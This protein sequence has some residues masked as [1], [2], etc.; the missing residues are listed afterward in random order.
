MKNNSTKLI[1]SIAGNNIIQV[2]EM[3]KQAKQQGA[4]LAEIRLDFLTEK[5]LYAKLPELFEKSPIDLI[6]T[7]RT[8]NEGGNFLDNPA[9]RIK[10]LE[11]SARFERVKYIDCELDIIDK[12]NINKPMIAS[13]HLL[14]K[15]TPE[16]ILKKLDELNR[17]KSIVS[18][19][20][21][22]SESASQ[23][24]LALEIL[25]KNNEPAII[26]AMN[27][28]GSVSRIAAKKVE[29]F[30]SFF[31]LEN[32]KKTAAGQVNINDAKLLYNWNEINKNTK[33]FGIVGCPVTHSQSPAIHNASFKKKN[34]NG[35]YTFLHTPASYEEFAKL[36]DAILEDTDLD[37]RGLSVTIP[38]KQNAIR[39]LGE[40]NCDPLAVKIGA[41]NTITFSE[42]K[43]FGTNTDCPAAIETLCKKM[44]ICPADLADRKV[45][46]LGS[47]GVA[48]A[49]VAGLAEFKADISIYNRT[50]E[51]AQFL[52]EEFGC[53]F[54]GLSDFSNSDA[55]I[56]IN[57]TPIGMTPD[58]GISPI[59]KLPASVKVVFDTIYNP[60]ET[61]LLQ[62]ARH[63]NCLCVTGLDMFIKQAELQFK[64]WTRQDAPSELMRSVV[65]K[66]LGL[67]QGKSS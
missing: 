11:I 9:E 3:L 18:K 14:K 46:V 50:V 48:R 58:C 41:V 10:L 31:A 33:L 2:S 39:W 57:C 19:L 43:A 34:Y 36:G 62:Q 15:V 32:Y 47:G 55:E 56:L 1:C 5:K 27:N 45:A 49:I 37:F 13:A 40:E 6:V 26:I 28:A 12:I 52:A 44:K 25:A 64:T 53:K 67:D 16:I 17:S 23:A 66:N 38:H 54:S 29:A 65:I 8:K 63:A 51:N 59:E 7:C 24:I 60:L 42:G 30:G 22:V 20:A 61:K 21:F 35:L 4:D